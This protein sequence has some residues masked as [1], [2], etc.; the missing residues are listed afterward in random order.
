MMGIM[1]KIINNNVYRVILWI[2]LFMMA[3]GSGILVNVGSEKH[4]AIKV[5]EQILSP[6][7]LHYI[8]KIAKH[9]K[10]EYRQKGIILAGK[11]P[12]KD[13]VVSGVSSLLSEHAMA[14]LQLTVPEYLINKSLDQTFGQFPSYFFKPDGELNEDMLSKVIAPQTIDEFIEGVHFDSKKSLLDS[15]IDLSVYT[16]MFEL[17]MQ[18]NVDFAHK[19][20]SIVSL[21][22]QKF[23][24]KSKEKA[25]TDKE[26]EAF[27]KKS[28]NNEQFKT[29]EKR[30]GVVWRL[31]DSDYNITVTDSD[32]KNYYDQ[33]KKKYLTASSEMQVRLLLIKAQPGK[34]AEVKEKIESLKKQADAD[35]DNFVKFVKDYSEDKESASKGG[36][37][38]FFD[39]DTT[40]LDKVM[41]KAAFESLSKDGQVS[42][43]IK[44]DRGYELIQRVKR[45]SAKYKDLKGVDSEIKKNLQLSKFKQRFQQ[46][47]NRVINQARYNPEALTKYVERYKANKKELTLDIRK[48]GLELTHLFKTDE[49]KYAVFFDKE[50]G[51]ILKCTE[52]EKSK[53]PPLNDVKNKVIVQYHQEQGKKM[54]EDALNAAVKEA[55]DKGIDAVAQTHDTKVQK[56]SFSYKDGKI[57]QSPILRGQEVQ[58]KLKSLHHSGAYI[59]VITAEE[60]LVV[61]LDD[62]AHRDEQLFGEKKEQ[63]SNTLFYAKKYQVKEGFIAS[64][65][66]SAKLDNAIEMKSEVAQYLKDV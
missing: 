28:K 41:V 21:P 27:Y 39:Q 60:G 17:G 30:A 31:D 49:H 50:T 10:E 32:I 57:D 26:L 36:L 20:Y 54:L 44:T 55:H 15:I 51:V 38:E 58:Q 24:A 25:L 23:I 42:A 61:R 65:Y 6:S 43:P 46:D 8:I 22:L 59:D 5:Y 40:K 56:A 1:R 14:S 9:Q 48:G 3:V 64:L 66:R 7:R 13:A 53:V 12:E 19:D 18:Y 16:P 29:Q 52:V 34:E 63:L 37:T 35:P 33:N 2:F 45:N 62:I 4:W 11:N 47:A